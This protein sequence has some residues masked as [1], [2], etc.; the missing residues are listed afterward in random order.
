MANYPKKKID[1]NSMKWVDDSKMFVFVLDVGPHKNHKLALTVRKTPGE[2]YRWT[3][4]NSSG[5]RTFYVGF[6]TS[7]SEAKTS[8]DRVVRTFYPGFATSLSEAK[9]SAD[10]AVDQ[11]MDD[12][13]I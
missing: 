3:L 4:T 8:A 10:R 13:V 6:A 9:T 2:K 12:G 5:L 7:L 11:L 1:G